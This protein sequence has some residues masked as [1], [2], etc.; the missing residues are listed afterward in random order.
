LIGVKTLFSLIFNL[1]GLPFFPYDDL[2]L[3][4]FRSSGLPWRFFFLK[5]VYVVFPSPFFPLNRLFLRHSF[6]LF[7][8]ITYDVCCASLCDLPII[9]VR[10]AEP[11]LFFLFS[12]ETDPPPLFTAF[13]FDSFSRRPMDGRPNFFVSFFSYGVYLPPP[14][15]EVPSLNFAFFLTII[16]SR[17]G[18]SLGPILA[19]FLPLYASKGQK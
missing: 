15:A 18:A 14:Y 13:V 12:P 3:T 6:L 5:S 9:R 11:L 19:L 4:L 16:S 1:T 8:E 2:T 10:K 7:L 17:F